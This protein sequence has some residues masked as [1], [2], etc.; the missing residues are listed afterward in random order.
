MNLILHYIPENLTEAL[1]WTL[2]HSLWQPLSQYPL[3]QF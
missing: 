1:G 2:L 3:Q